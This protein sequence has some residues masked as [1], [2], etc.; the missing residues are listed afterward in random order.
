MNA[1]TTFRL[2]EVVRLLTVQKSLCRCCCCCCC[3]CC[4]RCSWSVSCS[5][6]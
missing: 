2:V 1:K 4:C 3:C 6:V 5:P